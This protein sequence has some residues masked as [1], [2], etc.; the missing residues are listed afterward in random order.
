MGLQVKPNR[1]PLA[2]LPQENKAAQE[3]IAPIVRQVIRGDI[4]PNCR[5]PL[6]W[7]HLA[8]HGKSINRR[9]GGRVRY[10]K[11]KCCAHSWKATVETESIPVY[12]DYDSNA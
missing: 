2:A 8:G 12:D 10:Y 4:P 3:S 7:N 1:K 9:L 5:C 11:C 6:C